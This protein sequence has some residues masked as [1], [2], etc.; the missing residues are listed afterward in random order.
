MFESVR[1]SARFLFFVLKMAHDAK[2]SSSELNAGHSI[3][4]IHETNLYNGTIY[5]GV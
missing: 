5:D 2:C 4:T 3:N 1:C